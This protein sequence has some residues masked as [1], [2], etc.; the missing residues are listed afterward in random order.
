M[1]RAS[2]DDERWMRRCLELAARGAGRVSPNPMVGCVIVSPRGEVVAEGYHRRLG[3]PHG[4]ADA[5]ARCGFRAP[6]CTLY[7]NLEPCKHRGQRR[8]EPCAPRVLESGVARVVVGMMDPI[9]G[10]GGG[11]AWLA[12]RGVSVTRGVL[13]RECAELNRFFTT[14]AVARRP[15]VTLKAGVTLD[16]RVATHRGQSRWITGAAARR[17]GH[18]MRGTMDAILVGVET[19]RADDP[20]LTARGVRGR[21]PI[22]IVLDSRLRTPP[23][24]RLL[25]ANSGGSKARV[26]IATT[27][28]AT[29]AR[30]RR[31]EGAGAEVWR[32]GRRARVD[33]TALVSRL[34]ESEVSSVLVEGG[35]RVHRAFVD[36]DL[37]DELRLYLAPLALAGEA[38]SIGPGW[39]G[40]KGAAALSGAHRFRFVGEPTLLGPDLR[41]IL[42]PPRS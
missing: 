14:W 30:Q 6:G 33:L 37:V 26:I 3:G 22:R 10:H 27:A 36:A 24:A 39:I 7:V 17:D 9:R 40:G 28:A 23:S 8:T 12:R 34:A 21:D 32:L 42:R 18:R 20:A 11:A 19:V 5:L 29:A 38:G 31:L 4:E 13:R 2:A 1:T 25:P 41:V 16:G 15:Y 35:A